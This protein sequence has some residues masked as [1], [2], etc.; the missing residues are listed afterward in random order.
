M[1]DG[2]RDSV[3]CISMR[4]VV[5]DGFDTEPACDGGHEISCCLKVQFKTPGTSWC[6]CTCSDRGMLEDEPDDDMVDGIRLSEIYEVN[7]TAGDILA[8]QAFG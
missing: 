4:A 2:E 5:C 3:R 1:C 7:K 8:L 6:V